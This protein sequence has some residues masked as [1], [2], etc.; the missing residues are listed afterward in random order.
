MEKELTQRLTTSMSS[1]DVTF[2][3][4]NEETKPEKQKEMEVPRFS[5][6]KEQK[7]GMTYITF[8][9]QKRALICL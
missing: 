1:S 6:P 3:A 4:K 2:T 9:D 5:T 7:P 8:H